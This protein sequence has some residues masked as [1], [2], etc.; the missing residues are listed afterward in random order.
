LRLLCDVSSL[1]CDDYV[2]FAMIG[3]AEVGEMV[4]ERM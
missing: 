4:G 2:Y 3:P 1:L